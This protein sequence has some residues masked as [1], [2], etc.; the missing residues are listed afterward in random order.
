MSGYRPNGGTAHRT[1]CRPWG[2]WREGL[3]GENA[4]PE[5]PITG[6]CRSP[7]RPRPFFPDLPPLPGARISSL[8]DR[9][10]TPVCWGCQEGSPTYCIPSD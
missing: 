9:N 6:R 1:S 8:W 5:N 10:S 7:R 4:S 3:S 2:R